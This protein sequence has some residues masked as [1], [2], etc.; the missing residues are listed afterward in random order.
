MAP[1]AVSVVV[2]N[3]QI[4]VAEG[5]ILTMGRLLVITATVAFAIQLKALVP[6]T[7]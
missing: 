7:V 1:E 6:D 5:E 2:L 3:A 4:V